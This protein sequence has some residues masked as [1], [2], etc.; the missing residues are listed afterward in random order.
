MVVVFPLRHAA[1]K[2]VVPPTRVSTSMLTPAA[3][4]ASRIT[5]AVDVK[6][7]HAA[8]KNAFSKSDTPCSLGD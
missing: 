7:R 4:A 2:A 1:Y 6:P 8:R 3:A 5:L